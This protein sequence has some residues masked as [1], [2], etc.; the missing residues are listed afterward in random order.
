MQTAGGPGL[1]VPDLQLSAADHGEE[2]RWS[3]VGST[4]VLYI[5]YRNCKML[6]AI[7]CLLRNYRAMY[8]VVTQQEHYFKR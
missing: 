8:N 2:R 1:R 6:A 5:M 4:Y 3:T 7:N